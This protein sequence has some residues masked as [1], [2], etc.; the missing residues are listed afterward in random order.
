[1]LFSKYN[2]FILLILTLVIFI[3]NGCQSVNKTL[4][5]YNSITPIIY[6][7]GE[8]QTYLTL[9]EW[10]IVYL[11]D[12][13]AQFIKDTPPSKFSYFSSIKQFWSNYGKM[14]KITKD[15]YPTNIGYHVMII[16][17]GTS[18]TLEY[19]FKGIYENTIGRITEF[20]RTNG[21]TDEDAFAY[22]S[23]DDYVKFIRISPW[24]EYRFDKKLWHLWTNTNLIGKDQI[25]KTERKLILSAE[26]SF[27]AIY[28][29]I[30]KALT[31][32]SY[33]EPSPTTVILVNKIPEHLLKEN[34]DIKI[35]ENIND[36]SQLVSL[37]R[38]D[39]FKNFA[40]ILAENGIK[41]KEISGN[42]KEI[43]ITLITNRDWKYNIDVGEILFEEAIPSVPTQK[44]IAIRI[45]VESLNE[46]LINVSK[47]KIKL[48]HIYDY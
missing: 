21:L 29:L 12:E 35:I 44:R 9:P 33:E 34:P 39:A 30:I 16:V 8:E 45:S 37:P 38:Y 32:I 15:R 10:Y 23:A 36:Q 47:Q 7:R 13:Y 17:I 3:I 48:E 31:K 28:G 43:L 40:T 18:T 42:K 24:Y 46:L 11:S 1:M 20:T 14:Y 22:K 4:P 25:R 27:K 6:H 2:K 26:Y 5:E 19:G 41:F